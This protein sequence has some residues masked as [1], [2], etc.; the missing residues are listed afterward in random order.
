MFNSTKLNVLIVGFV[1]VFCATQCFANEEQQV[2]E[3]IVSGHVLQGF[4]H[5]VINVENSG[6]AAPDTAR[7]MALVPGGNLNDNGP[8]SGLIQYRGMFGP[9]MNV[10]LDGMYVNSAGPNWM[11]PPLHHI[12]VALL[13]SFEVTRG[14]ASVS[15]GSGIG[16]HVLANYKTSH[17]NKGND[18]DFT[19]QI[20]S[21]AH[22]ADNGYQVG[23]ILSYANNVHRFHLIGSQEQG[24]NQ[25]FGDGVIA[26]TKYSRYFLGAG[27]GYRSGEQEISFDYRFSHTGDSGTPALPMDIQFFDTNMVRG[28]YSGR[29][30]GYEIV[31]QVYYSTIDHRMNNYILRPAPDFSSLPMPPF[32][33]TDRR[34]V[35]TNS[36]GIGYSLI[37][38]HALLAGKLD[39]G[40]DGH[41][42]EQNATVRDPDVTSFF[43]ANFNQSKTDQFGFFA[44]W[45]REVLPDL[46]LE[47]GLRYDR[48]N[49]DTGTVDAQP[50]NLPMASMM[51]TP[52]YAIR[53]L[54]DAFNGMDRAVT[55]NNFDWVAKLDYRFSGTT[56]VELGFARKTRSPNYI[57]RYLWAPLEVNAGLGD[58]NNYVGN[59]GLNPEV[60]HQVELGLSWRS[61]NIY[62]NPR[63]YYRKVNDFI[64]GIPATNMFAIAVSKNANGDAA[65]LQ[66]T[67]VDAELYGFDAMYGMKLNDNWRVDGVL[68]YTRGKR[69]DIRDNLFRIA[70]L[71][72]RMTLRYERDRWSVALEGVV[73]ARQDRISQVITTSSAIGNNRETPGYGLLNIYGH[74]KLQEY[75]LRLNAGIDNLL[76]RAYTNH[77]SGFNRVLG[78]DVPIGMRLPGEGRNLYATLTYDW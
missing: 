70:P 69:T 17:F 65:P 27:Y 49:M 67:N 1:L 31:A 46:E 34:F 35:D 20:S 39:F 6:V 26:A 48:V 28:K 77:L 25:S 45:R 16:G 71:N 11:D 73:Y 38:S 47:I 2:P 9:R 44:E 40:V 63:A 10:R 23:G 18:F 76:D 36:N 37:M 68:S 56:T 8:V 12:P 66:F 14:I 53:M 64:Q 52:P 24:D 54:R 58:G 74:M 3:I 13:D 30:G 41:L 7:F 61:G 5:S 42:A 72:T 33:G 21:T 55:D 57:E 32:I 51:G 59:T 22:S 78:S 43:V 50:A 4:T 75:R 60:S 62:F 19:G 29:I 15:Y